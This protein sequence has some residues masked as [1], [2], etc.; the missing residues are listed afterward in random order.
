MTLGNPGRRLERERDSVKYMIEIYCRSVH[1]M[2][3]GICP[4]CRD[5]LD[6]SFNR[7]DKCRLLP[8]KP[9]CARCP[10][11]CYSPAM[12]ERIRAVMRYSSPKM[13]FRHPLLSLLHLFDGLNRSCRE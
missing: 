4:D 2:R 10:V 3:E 6:Y 11:T 9:T 7:L 13:A 1:G 5:M 12:R 8:D